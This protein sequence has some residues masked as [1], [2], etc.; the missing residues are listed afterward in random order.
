MVSAQSFVNTLFID[1]GILLFMLVVYLIFR[2]CRNRKV[3]DEEQE[4]KMPVLAEGEI[5][6]YE[7]HSKVWHTP[8]REI[9]KYCGL[10]GKNYL[11]LHKQIS[12]LLCIM[13]C[14]DIP[15]LIPIYSTGLESE[16]DMEK[17]GIANIMFTRDLLIAP[18]MFIFLN[19]I[20]SYI[21]IYAYLRE[22]NQSGVE[23]YYMQRELLT[24][25]KY[26]IE[27]FGIPKQYRAKDINE[28]FK[29]AFKDEFKDMDI[30]GYVVPDY[31]DAYI[32]RMKL[33]KIQ[34]RLDYY[35]S[36]IEV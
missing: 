26:T 29:R 23:V 34:E 14:I 21:L 7:L 16:E 10:E 11:I 32:D 13:V 3:K 24:I 1:I 30:E 19:S 17:M 35:N 36:Y 27:V 28:E 31:T 9:P 22:T 6:L 33:E 2:P 25:D 15:I 8:L 5:G 4:V 12:I 20:L 18:I